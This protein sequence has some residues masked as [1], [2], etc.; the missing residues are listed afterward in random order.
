VTRCARTKIR[1]CTSASWPKYFA[2][3]ETPLLAGRDFRAADRIGAL[4][5][6]IINQTMAHYYF[7]NVNPI[8]RRIR[9]RFNGDME[10]IAVVGDAKYLSLRE[11]TPRTLYLPCLQEEFPWSPAVFIR[12]HLPAGAAAATMRDAVQALDRSVSR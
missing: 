10:I 2:T 5:V 3:V 9:T 8:G 1:K 11:T 6:A 4:Q 7:R 12:I